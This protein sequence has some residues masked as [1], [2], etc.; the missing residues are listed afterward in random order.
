MRH[1]DKVKKLGRDRDHRRAMLNNL[2]TSILLKGLADEQMKRN[3]KTTIPKA[4]AV[5]SLVERLI[6]YAKKGDLSAK[7]QAA[8]FVKS[9]EAFKGLFEILGERY[10]DRQGG[11]TRILKLGD[12]RHGDNA[13][14]A[15]IALVEDEVTPKPKKKKGKKKTAAKGTAKSAEAKG[16]DKGT[17]AKPADTAE[18]TASGSTEKQAD[19][20][21]A[22]K[23]ASEDAVK[24]QA[25]TETKADAKAEVKKV[26]EK[27]EV[28]KAKV[29]SKTEP[30]AK[31]EASKKADDKDDKKS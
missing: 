1:G 28:K 2:A 16:A 23:S 14:M 25:K 18:D 12:F 21:P 4:K 5:R 7:R 31:K 30:K 27:P 15:Y 10:Q 26:E 13:E 3:V 22:E 19:A 6:S 20:K 9:K 11:Y 17:G 24:T 29:E 8:R